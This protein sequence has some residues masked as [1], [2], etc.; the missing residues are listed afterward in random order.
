[1]NATDALRRAARIGHVNLKVSNLERSLAFYDGVL[2]LR[3]T[4]RIGDEA[5]FLAYEGYHHDV[6][7]NVAKPRRLTLIEHGTC[8]SEV[9][10][11]ARPEEM[12]AS[13]VTW[14]SIPIGPR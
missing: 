8:R 4:K 1:M 7:I 11:S 10:F 14:K 5:A 12:P 6:C 9:C 2:G 13:Y 3:V